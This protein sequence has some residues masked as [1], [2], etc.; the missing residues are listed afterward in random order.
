MSDGHY[1]CRL[2]G[3]FVSGATTFFRQTTTL[4]TDKPNQTY[5]CKQRQSKLLFFSV[6]F[7]GLYASDL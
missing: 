7:F 1:Q 4:S 3:Q 5:K 6:F 2:H